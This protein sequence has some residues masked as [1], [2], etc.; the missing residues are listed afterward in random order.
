MFQSY[1]IPDITVRNIF[2]CNSTS[3]FHRHAKRPACKEEI[4]SETDAGVSAAT[5]VNAVGTC[6]L[7]S[8][9]VGML[10]LRK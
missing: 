8:A 6:V 4:G 5:T 3:C 7:Q 10:C 1:L 9:E 2:N